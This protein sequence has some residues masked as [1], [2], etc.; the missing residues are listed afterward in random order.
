MKLASKHYLTFIIIL[1]CSF[2]SP[3]VSATET[4][5]CTIGAIVGVI[6]ANDSDGDG[7]N[8]SCDLDDDNDG[9]LDTEECTVL[10][11]ETPFQVQNGASVNFSLTPVGTGFVLDIT[12]MDNSFNLTINGTS[13]TTEEIQFQQNGTSTGQNIRFKDGA[14]WGKNGI[15]QIY[16]YHNNTTIDPSTPIV[17]FV[18]DENLDVKMY[19]S[20]VPNGPLF[21]LE[22]FNNNS[23]NN[24]TW[25]STT[26]NNFIVSQEVAGPTYIFGR[27]YGTFKDCDVDNDGI[28]NDLDLDSDGDGCFDV[29]ESGGLDTN[30]DGVADGSGF[31]ND[32]LVSGSTGTYNGLTGF[33]TTAHSFNVNSTP[34]N[35]TIAYGNSVSFTIEA[36]S[37]EATEYNNGNP[38]YG[39]AGN[40]NDK[41]I[42]QWYLGDP[43]NGGN[44]LTDTGVYSNTNS[45]TL[46]IANTAG[47]YNNTYYVKVTH[48]ENACVTEIA[49]AQLL[50]NPCDALA[51]GNLDTD[52]DGVSDLCDLDDDN[53]GIKDDLEGCA[54]TNTIFE[55]NFGFGTSR[56]SNSNVANHLYDT[57][58]AIPDGSYAVVSS[59][60]SGLAHYNRTDRN[61]DVDADGD[62]NGRFLSIN[63]NSPAV[64]EIYRQND[65]TVNSANKHRFRVDFSG[66]CFG[67]N[68]TPIFTLLIEDENG[69]E[70]V[71]ITSTQIGVLNDDQWKRVTLEFTPTSSKVNIVI[72]NSQPKG[73]SGNDVGVDNILLTEIT[74]DVDT[75]KDGIPNSKDLDSDGDGC[76]D[77]LESEGVDAN[78]DGIIDGSG[79]DTDGLVLNSNGGYN[80]SNGNEL[81]AH[82]LAIVS[83]PVDKSIK[84]GQSTTFTVDVSAEEATEYANG[85]PIFGTTG[86]SNN[87]V[88]Y[89]WFLGDPLNGGV[90]IANSGVYSGANTKTLSISDVTG[91]DNSNYYVTISHANNACISETAN[92]TLTEDTCNDSPTSAALGFNVFTLDGLE[93]STNETEGAV[94]TGGDLTIAGNYQITT[95]DT[96]SFEINN[97]PVGL[98]VGGKVNYNSGNALQINQNT[99]VKIGE[100]NGAVVWYQ[101]QNS[102]FAPI[103][104]T[105]NSNYNANP[106]IALQ[107]NANQLGVSSTNNPVFESN[108][109]D[110]ASAFQTLK[111]NSISLSTNTNNADLTNPN[112]QSISNTNLPNQVKINLQDG[113]NYLNILGSDL[114][115]VSVFTYNNKPSASKVLVINVDASGTFNWNVW[116]QAGVGQQ[117]A[118]YIIYNFYNTTTLNI[119]GNST[120]EG[121]VLAPNADI[122]KTA[123][124]S[125]I[126]GQV[127]ANSFKH[128]GGEVHSANFTPTIGNCSVNNGVAPTAE[129]SVNESAQCLVGNSF[130]FTNNSNTGNTVQTGNP[131]TYVWNFGDNTTS[132]FMNPTK[133]YET[134]GTYTVTLEATNTFGTDTYT[135]EVIV[136]EDLSITL[137]TSSVDN[138]NGSVTKNFTIDNSTNFVSYSWS[139]L[140]QNKALIENLTSTN[141][142]A[143]AT[144]STAGLY[145]V[146]VSV[147]DVNGCAKTQQFPVTVTSDEVTGGNGGGVESESL[148]DAISKIY[149][150]RK[151]NSVPTN[152]VKSNANLY[153]K[154]KLKQAQPY[155]GKG[156][157]LLDMFPTELVAGNIANVTSP[158]D[159]LDYTIA[160]EV[161]S[162]DFSLDGKTKGV[163]LGIKTSDKIYNHTKASC[164]RLRGAEI[165]NIQK[166]QLEGYNFLMQGIKQRN[167]VVEYA[168]SF[169]TAKNNNDANYTIQTNWY[170]NNYIR[171]NDVY[172]FQVWSTNPQDT[173]KLVKDVL[174]NL[175]SF[176]PVTQTEIQKVPKT[177]AAK[178][179]REK[180]E[181]LILLRSTQKGLNTEIS[182]E[183]IYSE[184]ANNVKHRY[185]P[186]NTELEQTLRIDI[187]D[188]YEYDGLV[189]VD[190]EIEDAFYHA[191]GN[192]GLD[193]DKNY[194]EIE[195]Y[196]VWNNFNRD[197]KDD[198]HAINRSVEIKAKSEYDYLT[199]YKSLL[200]GTLS[201]DYSEYNYVA[202]TAKGSGLME[203]GLIKS[204]IEDWKAQYRVMVDLSE[205]E[206]TYYVPFEIFTSSATENTITADDLT[207]LT[208]TFLPVEAQTKEL[209]LVISDVRFTKVA[210]D[211]ETVNKIEKFE[212]EFMAYPNPSKGNVNVLLF[213]EYDTEATVTLTD[214]NGKTIYRGTTNLTV[215]KNELDYNFN[216]KPGVLFLKVTSQES[217]YGTSKILFR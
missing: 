83:N 26:D 53:D 108:V 136:R 31:N 172:N 196:F 164:D 114:N 133:V 76:L 194:T 21:E 9:I 59:L 181:L 38:V 34:T 122:I 96:G 210:V 12:K 79:F 71:S 98:V 165:L 110:F 158:T 22:L 89:Q 36:T 143:S 70:L 145:Y 10:I 148:G 39:T 197:Y 180:S 152:F 56:E 46:N 208:F 37:E 28:D 160:D 97:V 135:K 131:I 60:S 105:N 24:F 139:L 185:N 205:D 170:V 14:L 175:K 8:D 171:F 191:D 207:T 187:A 82:Q 156:Q 144:I 149:V 29:V 49:S 4:D 154:A 183:E 43:N 6:T 85:S 104:I 127:I 65:I 30:N 125:N 7:I 50:S 119:E 118:P 52:L 16:S 66:L 100:S 178:I 11:G 168:I 128:A 192:W 94:A 87:D 177:F 138:S 201:A 101:D 55:E 120:I 209:D 124:Q 137:S 57:E 153:N 200:P 78:N 195:N 157:T 142:T 204:S 113:V 75:D 58:G 95:N 188:G 19:G 42:Y 32:G 203:L 132:T 84:V 214:I 106:R 63:I 45:K 182:M 173:Q 25:N 51:S 3:I 112:G 140:D 102:A 91:L 121:T 90:V 162:V 216:V 161:L 123:N 206:Q 81:N 184:T 18:I 13:L 179:S 35:K 193:Y 61:G 199:I 126:E 150:G 69:N 64:S 54:E 146:E 213:S 134:V 68:D 212:N 2:Y 202:F 130:E 189:K 73:N 99:Y 20:K 111:N 141:A 107:A 109:I 211:E 169:A 5:P 147:V 44:A 174:N 93:L 62:S 72:K 1:L 86:N 217:D 176:M 40:A 166:V 74:C 116:N 117:D 159:I 198:E 23:F 77:V 48:S 47:L 17:R 186:V 215:G 15:P 33:E 92:A 129:F 190:G 41:I 27:V 155:Q 163:V 167:G 67:C 151:K 88:L 115:N 80:G 103:R